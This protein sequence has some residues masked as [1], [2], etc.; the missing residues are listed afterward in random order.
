M[1]STIEDINISTEVLGWR[2][3][4]KRLQIS[5]TYTKVYLG[6]IRVELG[7]GVDIGVG[8]VNEPP[9]DCLMPVDEFDMIMQVTNALLSRDRKVLEDLLESKLKIQK[10]PV[11]LRLVK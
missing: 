11:R 5:M 1:F 10:G 4:F 6:F 7:R 8:Y 9:P 3:G 2:D